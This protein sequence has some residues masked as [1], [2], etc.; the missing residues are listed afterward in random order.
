MVYLCILYLCL[1]PTN[2]QYLLRSSWKM[3]L[4]RSNKLFFNFTFSFCPKIWNIGWLGK[5]YNDLF[6]KSANIRGKRGKKWEKE[7]I[8]LYIGEKT[9]FLEIGGGAKIS[10][11]GQ[12]FGP[13]P[14]PWLYNISLPWSVFNYLKVYNLSPKVWGESGHVSYFRHLRRTK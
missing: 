6:W 7:D 11:F 2:R 9:Q 3:S 10:S 4:L 14:E 13:A 12:I 8:S 5:K 1:C